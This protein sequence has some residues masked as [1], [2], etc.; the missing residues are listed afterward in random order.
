M[1]LTWLVPLSRYRYCTVQYV[2]AVCL[3]CDPLRTLEYRYVP[4]RYCMT[5]SKAR[6]VLTYG[7]FVKY[8]YVLYVR[9]ASV[10]ERGKNSCWRAA[11]RGAGRREKTRTGKSRWCRSQA[12]R[13]SS[14]PL[15]GYSTVRTYCT[16]TGVEPFCTR[17]LNQAFVGFIYRTTVRCYATGTRDAKHLSVSLLFYS[18]LNWQFIAWKPCLFVSSPQFT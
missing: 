15:F 18:S 4:V 10:S 3:C 2:L 14:G 16:G 7:N 1:Q 5:A 17:V 6:T 8:S 13:S 12:A 9:M 11:A